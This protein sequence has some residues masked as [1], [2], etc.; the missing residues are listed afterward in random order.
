M[1]MILFAGFAVFAVFALIM[2]FT[3]YRQG[4]K[5]GGRLH[6][7]KA[8]QPF[9]NHKPQKEREASEAEKRRSEEVAFV[10]NYQ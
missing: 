2:V 6:D 4:L 5:D 8:V 1:T 7:R 9:F 3:A 10:D